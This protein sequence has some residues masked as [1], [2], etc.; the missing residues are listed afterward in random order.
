MAINFFSGF[1]TIFRL[2]WTEVG[3]CVIQQTRKHTGIN[4]CR[5]NTQFPAQSYVIAFDNCK[6]CSF[7]IY[8]DIFID[9]DIR[10]CGTSSQIAVSRRSDGKLELWDGTNSL[11]VS[12]SVLPL[13]EWHRI[14]ISFNPTSNSVKLYLDSIE[15]ISS[16]SASSSTII[17]GKYGFLDDCTEW[18]IIYLDDVV[19]D[20][21]E[22]TEDLGD[23]RVLES[24]VIGAG[25]YTE[26]DSYQG[27]SIHWQNVDKRYVSISD[28]N[29]HDA[30]TAVKECYELEDCSVMGLAGDDVIKAV[31]TICYMK[32]GN[33][34]GSD[35]NILV[36]DNGQDYET[37]VDLTTD[38]ADYSRIDSVMPNGGGDW[39]QSRFNAF[40]A[41]MS[42]GPAVAQDPYI[43]LVLVMVA[44]AS[45]V[46]FTYE[47]SSEEN[48][49]VSGAIKSNK[50]FIGT[51][52][53]NSFV[54]GD[55]NLQPELIS[56]VVET[57]GASGSLS[58][59]TELG[60]SVVEVS[61]TSG[62][63]GSL[64]ILTLFVGISTGP[65]N[66]FGNLNLQLELISS[67]VETFDVSGSLN[68]QPGL[69]GSIVSIFNIS[70]FTITIIKWKKDKKIKSAPSLKFGVSGSGICSWDF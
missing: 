38:F 11:G 29:W 7:W 31:K 3:S 16:T 67:I 47:G 28:Y 32:R 4:A 54:S 63:L 6:R 12:S 70:I 64:N 35:H 51:S 53:E 9:S 68:L 45:S 2:E 23:I 30:K 62:S 33:G 20:D 1:E 26:F 13:D 43:A 57:S 49:S 22:S 50:K 61:G 17:E 15:E 24:F 52:E 40:E 10:I 44:F 46:I 59:I 65:F 8:I 55:L 42:Y 66:V 48:S 19:Q 34:G 27:S 21:T 58:I 5:I 37:V 69:I 41:G 36:R 60:S 25:N 56:F 18:N 14:S 39:T